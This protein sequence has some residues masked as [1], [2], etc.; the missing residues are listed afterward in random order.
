[1]LVRYQCSEMYNG[2]PTASCGDDGMYMTSG[3]CRRECGAPPHVEHAVP[4]FNN[5]EVA[6]GWFVGMGCPYDCEPGLLLV[7]SFR[8]SLWYYI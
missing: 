6:E 7:G 5:S 1:M 2:T 8:W 3:R 4:R